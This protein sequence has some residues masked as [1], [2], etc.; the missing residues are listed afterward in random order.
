MTTVA[1]GPKWR[2]VEADCATWVE[3]PV[4]M[5]CLYCHEPIGENDQGF[6][7]PMMVSDGVVIDTACHG[8]C[9]AVQIIGHLFDICRCTGWNTAT[10]A[11]GDA[12]WRR[13]GHGPRPYVRPTKKTTRKA[14]RT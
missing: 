2:S 14:T 4:G 11:A 3:V 9:Q 10:K 5:L 6:K 13:L 8:G 12:L 1:F 7:V